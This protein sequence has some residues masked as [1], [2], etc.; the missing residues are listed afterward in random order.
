MWAKITE[1]VQEITCTGSESDEIWSRLYA[2]LFRVFEIFMFPRGH[3]GLKGGVDFLAPT[4]PDPRLNFYLPFKL[5][6]RALRFQVTYCSSVFTHF[7][8][9]QNTCGGDMGVTCQMHCS[10]VNATLNFRQY[11]LTKDG[12][13]AHDPKRS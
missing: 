9:L 11:L 4:R 10:W 13:V 8:S 7:I 5:E 2:V 6:L 12:A 1:L 3:V